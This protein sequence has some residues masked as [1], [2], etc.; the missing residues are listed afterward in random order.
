MRIK[1]EQLRQSIQKYLAPL[2]L[3]FGD[4]PFVIQES[5]DL[6]RWYALDKGYSEREV[7]D[8]EAGF[9]WGCLS[10]AGKRISL[11]GS[12][13]LIE[14]NVPSGKLGSSGAKRLQEWCANLP[15]DVLLVMLLPRLDRAAQQAK[16]F[17]EIESV[18]VCVQANSVTRSQLP[19]WLSERLSRQKQYAD[20][21]TLSFLADMTE[22]NLLASW[23]EIQKLGLLY[24]PGKLEYKMVRQAVLPVARYAPFD[25]MEAVLAGE[26]L[27]VVRILS[28]LEQE[29]CEPVI[30]LWAL[31]KEVR[32]LMGLVRR[33]R[34]GAPIRVAMQTMRIWPSRAAL[35]ERAIHRISPAVLSEALY[36]AADLDRQIKGVAVN[37]VWQDLINVC[38]LLCHGK[39]DEKVLL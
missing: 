11:F 31:T 2:Y 1:S 4:E 21:D 25:L 16:W 19:F 15:Q 20:Q 5:R 13:Q 36:C 33:L 7:L 18:G 6:V 17:A 10:E 9:D 34:A 38:L 3:I 23:Q 26:K 28:S 35:I 22:G 39:Q 37:N 14:L 30:I 32:I 12:K 29:G 8:V 27:R 24:P